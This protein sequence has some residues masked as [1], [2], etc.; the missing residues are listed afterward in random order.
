MIN[1]QKRNQKLPIYS[2]K[3]QIVCFSIIKKYFLNFD[4]F[5]RF[6]HF[7]RI[8]CYC[9]NIILKCFKTIKLKSLKLVDKKS[10]IFINIFEYIYGK[11]LLLKICQQ[12]N[13]PTY[14]IIKDLKFFKD[15]GTYKAKK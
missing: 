2:V 9:L 13:L 10:I 11:K 3:T 14:D 8:I 7:L 5:N 15:K 6:S 1:L 12:E 4:N